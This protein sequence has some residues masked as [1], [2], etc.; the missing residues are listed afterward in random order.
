MKTLRT[1]LFSL[2]TLSALVLAG[3]QP[4]EG[5]GE[6]AGSVTDI[7]GAAVRGARIFVDG[8]FAAESSPIG[9]FTIRSV[10]GGIRTLTARLTKNGVQYSG[11][12]RVE[13]F[14]RERT[15]S[16]SIVM[17]R[18]SD[19]G[20]LRGTVRDELG[21][22]LP[23][24]RVFVGG[25][26]GSWTNW[27][28]KNGEY[29]IEGLIGGFQYLVEASGRGYENDNT[30]VTISSGSTSTVNF[31]LRF[32]SNEGQQA[33]ENLGAVAWT[34]PVQPNRSREE[35]MAYERIKRLVHP[36]SARRAQGRDFPEGHHIEIDLFWGFAQQRELLG[37]GIY[38]G[39]SPSNLQAIDFL[40]DPLAT[41]YADIDDLLTP[42]VRYFYAVTRL[43][44][45][46]PNRPGSQSPF[47]NVASAV[48]L[49]DLEVQSPTFNPLVF[50]WQPVFN[51][52]TYVVYLFENYPS[53]DEA[54]LWTSPSTATNFMFYSGPALPPVRRYYYVVV[55]SG[56]DDTSFTISQI[57]SFVAQ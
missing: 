32:S 20:A 4:A 8:Q 50:R 27:T 37:Y 34:S 31:F 44:T 51:A 10:T 43:N 23:G 45:D 5:R 30:N 47:S 22:P 9:T 56:F 3:C 26:L 2:P 25:P 16:V 55:G 29:R 52:D 6:I 19:M 14:D 49:G 1:L 18:T 13:V 35:M 41:F 11:W 54:P 39:S 36:E 24:V 28:D 40:R 15:T 21:T 46:Y 42:S 33:P 48:P 7:N 38:R 53:I 57:D 12:N 17:G